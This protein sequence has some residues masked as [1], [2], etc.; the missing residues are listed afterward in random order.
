ME[1]PLKGKKH[2]VLNKNNFF[3]S[4]EQKTGRQLHVRKEWLSTQSQ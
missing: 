4:H 3:S 2:E 1:K